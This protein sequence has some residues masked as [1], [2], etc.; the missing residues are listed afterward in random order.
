MIKDGPQLLPRCQERSFC[1]LKVGGEARTIALPSHCRFLKDCVQ[2]QWLACAIVAH[3]PQLL[4]EA[5]HTID[6]VDEGRHHVVLKLSI[7][8]EAF[9]I[10]KQQGQLTRDVF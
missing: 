8:L 1:R 10:A 3:R 9:G 2:C 7:I 4:Q 5:V 6:R